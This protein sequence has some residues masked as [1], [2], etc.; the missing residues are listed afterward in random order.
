MKQEIEIALNRSKSRLIR[1]WT[2]DTEDSYT[3]KNRKSTK[4]VH[5]AANEA[6]QEL[7][8]LLT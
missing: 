6:E 3:D 4:E 2:M 8:R 1:A 7:R 5:D